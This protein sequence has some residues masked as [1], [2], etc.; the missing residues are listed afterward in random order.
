[1]ILGSTT[2]TTYGDTTNSASIG[3]N[4]WLVRQF[5]MLSVAPGDCCNHLNLGKPAFKAGLRSTWSTQLELQAIK[6]RSYAQELLQLWQG[7]DQTNFKVNN[8]IARIIIS[9]IWNIWR[10]FWIQNGSFVLNMHK[11][12]VVKHNFEGVVHPYFFH[13][14]L[15]LLMCFAL[16]STTAQ[17]SKSFPSGLP[18]IL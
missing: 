10:F 15:S 8:R 17:V 4:N 18:R 9:W 13:N 3:E 6:A 14:D 7:P 2:G 16:C 12:V 11:L 1:M 5:A